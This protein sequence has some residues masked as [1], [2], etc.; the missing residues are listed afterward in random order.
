MN[1]ELN[2]IDSQIEEIAQQ[3]NEL[4]KELTVYKLSDG[5]T[6]NNNRCKK[7]IIEIIE[8]TKK[9]QTLDNSWCDVFASVAMGNNVTDMPKIEVSYDSKES[10]DEAIRKAED[11]LSLGFSAVSHE[12]VEFYRNLINRQY[13]F[14]I[15]GYTEKLK[16]L[17]N[18]YSDDVVGKIQKYKVDGEDYKYN[19]GGATYEVKNR[20]DIENI[21]GLVQEYENEK[22][23]NQDINPTI[24][25][26][27]PIPLSQ[28]SFEVQASFG[29][30]EKEEIKEKENTINLKNGAKVT[31]KIF[32][33]TAK[34]VAKLVGNKLVAVKNNLVNNLKAYYSDISLANNMERDLVES[35]GLPEAKDVTVELPEGNIEFDQT[36]TDYGMKQPTVTE[37]VSVEP[38]VVPKNDKEA[39]LSKYSD[40][41]T[42]RALGKHVGDIRLSQEEISFTVDN[43]LDNL[44]KV[45]EEKYGDNFVDDIMN[46]PTTEP[47]KWVM[48]EVSKGEN[49]KQVSEN[50]I[51]QIDMMDEYELENYLG[52]LTL[53]SD[54]LSEFHKR[55][56]DYMQ[57]NPNS[58]EFIASKEALKS[59]VNDI[60][61]VKPSL[62]VVPEYIQVS[63]G[64]IEVPEPIVVHVEEPTQP[65]KP[66]YQ[67]RT[68]DTID[69]MN[70]VELGE[71]IQDLNLSIEEL[72]EFKSAV[73]KYKQDYP[74]T[75]DY[76]AQK[77]CVKSIALQ[78]EIE[79]YKVARTSTIEA[80]K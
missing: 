52:K 42:E 46:E 29:K 49:L 36:I 43:Y 68:V 20:Q 10:L 2:S 45:G 40:L 67:E 60:D 47:I 23:I 37:K 71:Y 53:S 51:N 58:S 56:N 32:Q 8:K 31:V 76:M 39:L 41:I 12:F 66:V 9:A 64:N 25:F 6:G 69:K 3:I 17:S 62:S 74:G 14:T 28:T 34:K 61:L 22:D 27:K 24:E 4:E 33:N 30:K 63:N 35:M 48:E 16:E 79:G 70:E 55:V 54:D 15:N 21:L 26:V 80:R 73:K 50:T 13:E 5:L 65:V 11:V 7:A 75:S 57:V 19:I 77:A 72:K 18:A 44:I 59:M 78:R 38:V 1:N